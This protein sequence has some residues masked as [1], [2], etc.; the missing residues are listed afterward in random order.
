MEMHKNT[1]LSLAAGLL[2]FI[3]LV[4]LLNSV[5]FILH[6]SLLPIVTILSFIAGL[7]VTYWAGGQLKV[8][9][10]HVLPIV[11]SCIVA[12]SV[13]LGGITLDTTYDGNNYHKY[14]IGSLKNG[15]NPVYDEIQN[16]Y[17]NTYPKA[18]WIFASSIYQLTGDIE[19]GKAINFMVLVAVFLV[20]FWYLRARLAARQS[21]L[22]ALLLALSPIVAAQL[23][24]NYVDGIMGSLLIILTVFLNVLVDKKIK[25]PKKYIY[26][27]VIVLITVICNL[28]FTGVVYSGILATTYLLY[29]M[30][31]RDWSTTKQLLVVGLASLVVAIGIVGAPTYVRNTIVHGH[32]LYPIMGKGS[33][34][35]LADNVPVT[36]ASKNRVHKFIESNLGE[37][38]NISAV[39]GATPDKLDSRLK[40]PF[41]F[42]IDELILLSKGSPDLRQAGY[43]VWFGGVLLLSLVL[44]VY[45]A[46]VN[47]RKLK[48]SD[49]LLVVLPIIPIVVT[50]LAIE[51]SWW[52]RYLPQLILFPGIVLT[53]LYMN[54][55]TVLASV[56]SFALLFNV[57]LITVLQLSYQQQT[58][59]QVNDRIH[60][61]IR[62]DGNSPQEIVVTVAYGD[63]VGSTYNMLDVCDNLKIKREPDIK[64]IDNSYTEI[65][66]G[67]YTKS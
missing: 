67:I 1:A 65:W 66:N 31:R 35:I 63:F 27:A 7:G 13:F 40:T 29:V 2:T 6:G 55:K 14:A 45:L 39:W 60:N 21:A 9:K 62:C 47:R 57:T 37:T 26:S 43:G 41:M 36:Y 38:D 48:H 42:N 64:K 30:Y 18:S 16:V 46:I 50:A 52:A 4:I 22:L 15:W 20:V 58:V 53:L 51:D 28:K 11:L 5:V 17:S 54:K 34:P 19:T 8:K 49:L 56:L 12:G 32:P 24:N 23:F 25:L 44:A 59:S 33:I 3:F 10:P 61:L